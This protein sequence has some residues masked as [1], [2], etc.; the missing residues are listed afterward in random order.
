MLIPSRCSFPTFTSQGPERQ[1]PVFRFQ[2]AIRKE[3][4]EYKSNEMEVH[5]SS[6]HLTRWDFRVRECRGPYNAVLL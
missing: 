2:A 1:C 5:A 3:L 6:K 4:N